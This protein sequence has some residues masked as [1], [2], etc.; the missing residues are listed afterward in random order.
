MEKEKKEMQCMEEEEVVVV[1]SLDK[2]SPDSQSGNAPA[3][4]RR[5]QLQKNMV[6]SHI[7]PFVFQHS[8]SKSRFAKMI[9]EASPGARSS[10]LFF[11]SPRSS[12]FKFPFIKV[13]FSPSSPYSFSPFEFISSLGAPGS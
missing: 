6:L 5:G 13:H 11:F 2:W 9:P 1:V 3:N 8:S 4:G 10:S 7:P 12:L